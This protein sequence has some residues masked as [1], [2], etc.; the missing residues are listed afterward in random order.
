MMDIK[1]ILWPIDFSDFSRHALLHALQLARWFKSS[2]TVL[3]VYPPPGGPPPV[4]FSG[5]PGPLPP[6]PSLTVSPEST[7]EVML[8]EVEKFASGIDTTGVTLRVDARAGVPV[9][10]ILDEAKDQQSDL[11]VLGTHGH[12][13]FDRCIW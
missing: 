1:S 11:I 8:A 7:H 9:A 6:F 12:S 13:G 3:Y 4:V 2:L 10:T 5:L